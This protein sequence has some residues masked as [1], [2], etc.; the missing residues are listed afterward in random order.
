[1][2]RFVRTQTVEQSIGKQG[3][4]S[5]GLI[6]ADVR[7]RAVEGTTAKVVATFTIS[8]GSDDEADRIFEELKLR[9]NAGPSH[10]RLEERDRNRGLSGIAHLFDRRSVDL[11]VEV[12]GPVDCRLEVDGVSADITAH[13]FTGG[14]RY[15]TVSGD[16]RLTDVAGAIKI[17]AVSGDV[18]LAAVG[19]VGLQVSTVSGDLSLEAP[20]FVEL[21]ASTVSGDVEVDG[22]LET[23]H[24]HAIDTVS[25]DASLALVGGATISVHGLSTVISASLPH[26]SE[27]PKDRR[28]LIFD[29]GSAQVTFNSM[30]GDLKVSRSQ[31]GVPQ[32]PSSAAPTTTYT[33]IE[34]L[35]ALEA[36]EIDVDEAAR[37]LGS[38]ER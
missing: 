1:M 24:S 29:D 19:A 8:A 28:R 25:G 23:D 6:S 17:E 21:R 27:G 13:G 3:R 34:T 10:V 36:G 4:L 26:R 2:E 30:S 32:A 7:L 12:D 16:M 5:V 38:V 9:V 35:R 31:R 14:Q 20:S 18:R 33:A 11:S 22:R 15:Q 37:R